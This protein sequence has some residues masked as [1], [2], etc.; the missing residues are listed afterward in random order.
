M[1]FAST[2]AALT[3]VALTVVAVKVAV[4]T[5]TVASKTPGESPLVSR[6]VPLTTLPF[7]AK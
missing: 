7:G 4:V 5:L 6:N 3:V 1:L 2:V